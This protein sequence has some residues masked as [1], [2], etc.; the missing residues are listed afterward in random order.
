MKLRLI[1]FLVLLAFSSSALQKRQNQHQQHDDGIMDASR[2][3][4]VRQPGRRKTYFLKVDDQEKVEAVS[5]TEPRT[6]LVE[7][8]RIDAT[9]PSPSSGVIT[10]TADDNLVVEDNTN[11][12]AELISRLIDSLW[13]TS[14][15]DRTGDSA[16]SLASSSLSEIETIDEDGNTDT[17]K[18]QE[19]K[20]EREGS[21]STSTPSTTFI[22]QTLLGVSSDDGGDEFLDTDRP[23]I[24]SP[25]T[26]DSISSVPTSSPSTFSLKW[27]PTIQPTF[28]PTKPRPSNKRITSDAPTEEIM[29]ENEVS[30][31]TFAVES[32]FP[33]S[34]VTHQLLP[35]NRPT[36]SPTDTHKPTGT[37]LPTVTHYPTYSPT[38][39]SISMVSNSDVPTDDEASL[40]ESPIKSS[41]ITPSD[42]PSRRPSNPPSSIIT[43]RP[44]KNSSDVPTDG[45]TSMPSEMPSIKPTIRK[46]MLKQNNGIRGKAEHQTTSSISSS[47][48]LFI[49]PDS[50]TKNIPRTDTG[51]PQQTQPRG[52]PNRG[53]L[54]PTRPRTED[55]EANSVDLD[56]TLVVVSSLQ[57]S[58]STVTAIFNPYNYQSNHYFDPLHPSHRGFPRDGVVRQSG[59]SSEDDT[60]SQ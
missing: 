57:S 41:N 48:V 50:H 33:S 20:V 49:F 21:S 9:E 7:E 31:N 4:M 53:Y 12:R 23:P 2:R 56:D 54:R 46:S 44:S 34:L 39:G 15:E 11:Y 24:F 37:Y 42:G 26:S 27:P 17:K 58:S 43:S 25:T 35:T 51:K 10:T 45:P 19:N 14:R 55:D 60:G 13:S 36:F 38:R 22:P 59:F 16:A 6:E 32:S 5:R 18:K 29:D 52:V 8:A 40:D 30:T 28:V 1:I 3:M 47:S